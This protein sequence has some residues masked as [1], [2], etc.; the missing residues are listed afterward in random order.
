MMS[1]P[2]ERDFIVGTPLPLTD[3]AALEFMRSVERSV[4]DRQHQTLSIWGVPETQRIYALAAAFDSMIL[5]ITMWPRNTLGTGQ[6][7]KLMHEG[8]VH[9]LRWITRADE[10][11]HIRPTRSDKHIDAAGDCLTYATQYDMISKFHL[12]VAR[13]HVGV[14]ADSGTR[15][16]RFTYLNQRHP[17]MGPLHLADLAKS[18]VRR[19][20]A[21]QADGLDASIQRNID[22]SGV[23][24]R[25][26]HVV[27]Q[28]PAVL[29]RSILRLLE[30][31]DIDPVAQLPDD[32]SLEGFTVG[33]F[34]RLRAFLAA[35]SRS[36]LHVYLEQLSSGRPQTEFMPTQVVPREN[37]LSAAHE[38]TSLRLDTIE[39]IVSRLSFDTSVPKRD[40]FLQPLLADSTALLWSPLCVEFSRPLRN[41]LK[42]MSRDPRLA[43]HAA[44]I[45]GS[46]ESALMDAFES[47]L[48]KSARFKFSR[49]RE[50]D[51]GTIRTEI[52]L[53]AH[54]P[55]AP[56]QVLIVQAKAGLEADEINEVDAMTK[57]LLAGQRQATRA[58]DGLRA[59]SL[60]Q[61]RNVARA[62]PWDQIDKYFAL[63]ITASN[64]PGSQYDHSRVPAVSVQTLVDH[65]AQ[66]DLTT[67]RSIVAAVKARGWQSTPP[68]EELYDQ[69]R[70]GDVTYQLPVFKN[71]IDL[72]T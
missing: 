36:A 42:L 71:E 3:S 20:R 43:N 61:R 15:I 46:R 64:E 10:P 5:P 16:I 56:S 24:F 11:L 53:L 41:M 62:F 69:V 57:D 22:D 44:T 40:P 59:L 21:Q 29:A 33:E 8:L 19:Q 26:G 50:I 12:S 55:H 38:A 23:G 65:A 49:N 45:I 9:S 31:R 47:A 52:D 14:E 37:F 54:S 2:S 30:A 25:D 32:T 51:A 6:F 1:D 17:S 67:P 48:P 34:L 4:L 66:A 39:A 63:V 35:W 70:V 68:T 13:G 28:K 7:T 27:F 18:H 58:I 72:S 60:D